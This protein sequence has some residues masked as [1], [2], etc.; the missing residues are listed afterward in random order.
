MNSK[1]VSKHLLTGLIAATSISLFSGS[2]YAEY[3]SEPVSFVVP[4]PPG[5]L[6]DITTRMIANDFQEMYDTPAA[7]INKPGGGGGPFPGAISVANA[8]ANG[9]TIGSFPMGIPIV[10]PQIGIPD[11]SPNPFEPISIYLTYPFVIVS[12]KNA[13][14]QNLEEMAEYGKKNKLILG[15]FG[16]PLI[17]SKVTFALA[18]KM[19]FEWGSEAA[20]DALDCNTL[21]SGDVDVMNT[22]LQLIL[23][24]LDK[25]NVLASVTEERINKIPDVR[26]V[27]E[28]FPE[29]KIGLWNGIFVHKDT[30]QDIK[31]KI[32]MSVK[33]TVLS[34]Q[35]KELSEKTGMLAYW[36]GTEESEQTIEENAQTLININ[37]IID[38]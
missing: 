33:K 18:K 15:H 26:T 24:C 1:R 27:G 11:L 4:F 34:D 19:D 7:V 8:K 2:L 17:P 30:P 38:N 21:A 14:Y 16:A 20:F 10:G 37:N 22:T 9:T 12:S 29:L 5:D 32:A 23:P 36:K 6:E 31:D 25:V 35:I 28:I 3:P 13:P